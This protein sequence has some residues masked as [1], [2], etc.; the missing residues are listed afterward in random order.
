MIKL[1]II[2]ISSLLCLST[3]CQINRN[4][5]FYNGKY[6]MSSWYAYD[7]DSLYNFKSDTIRLTNQNNSPSN[8]KYFIEWRFIPNKKKNGK[9]FEKIGH[10]VKQWRTTGWLKPEKF[11][12]EKIEN[13]DYISIYIGEEKETYKII[14]FT[15]R[16]QIK[17]LTLLRDSTK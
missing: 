15:R 12:I 11:T 16:N 4:E 9:N 6:E 3:Y 17:T 13:K 10:D 5:F 2:L 1:H 7:T 8:C 14:S